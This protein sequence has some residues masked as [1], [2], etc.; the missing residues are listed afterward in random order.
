MIQAREGVEPVSHV[1]PSRPLL[2]FSVIYGEED[3]PEEEDVRGAVVKASVRVPE[4]RR[5]RWEAEGADALRALLSAAEFAYPPEINLQEEGAMEEVRTLSARDP[6]EALREFVGGLG[7]PEGDAAL[8][9]EEGVDVL[10][11]CNIV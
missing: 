9:L 5:A 3:F 4:E 6:E 8:V 10:R 7:I 1:I 11:A 2:Q